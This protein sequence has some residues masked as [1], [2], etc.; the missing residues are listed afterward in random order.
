MAHALLVLPALPCVEGD[1][2]NG[3]KWS[4]NWQVYASFLHRLVSMGVRREVGTV[5]RLVI[6]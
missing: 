1:Q 4:K 2:V 3:P 6:I 5:L